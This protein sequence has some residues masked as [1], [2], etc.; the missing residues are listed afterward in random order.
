MKGLLGFVAFVL[1]SQG[2]G[3]LAY[4]LTDGRFHLWALTH[5]LHFLDGFQVYLCLGLV[6]LGLAVAALMSGTD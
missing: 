6:V 1:I 4:E 5:R 3:G 2:L